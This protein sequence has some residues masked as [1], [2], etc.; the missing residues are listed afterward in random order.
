[1][2]RAGALIVVTA[3]AGVLAAAAG[4]TSSA[5][6]YYTLRVH[7][8]LRLA[9]SNVLCGAGSTAGL[10]YIDCGIVNSAGKELSGSY[11]SLLAK[12]G[13]TTVIADG[14]KKIL[15]DKT[16]GLM[17]REA[18]NVLHAGD[19]FGIAG[20][21]TVFCSAANV[22]GKPTVFCDRVDK[23]GNFVHNSYAFGI[24]DTVVT[25]LMWDSKGHSKLLQSWP[26]NG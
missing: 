7:E 16:A 11:V 15:F 13:R 9:G 20:I 8:T 14:G 25:A 24:S 22:Q 4:A 10:T 21:A 2:R 23:K 12:N 5:G 6:K 1:M 19:S 3:I 26:E 18:G 17:E